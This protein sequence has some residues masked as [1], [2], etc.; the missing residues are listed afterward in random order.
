VTTIKEN[1]TH[2]RSWNNKARVAIST[3]ALFL[4]KLMFV[5]W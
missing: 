5:S 1:V 4:L 2:P 3:T